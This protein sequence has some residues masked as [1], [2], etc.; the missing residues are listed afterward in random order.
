MVTTAEVRGDRTSGLA[1]PRWGERPW[2]Y[3][4]GFCDGR[5]HAQ[6]GKPPLRSPSQY[7]NGFYDGWK[8]VRRGS[9]VST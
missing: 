7:G 4:D 3:E 2:S 8:S 1:P 6:D 9:S 5:D